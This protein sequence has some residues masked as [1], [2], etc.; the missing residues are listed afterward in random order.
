MS[1]LIDKIRALKAKTTE[2]GCTEDEALAAMAMARRLMKKHG[3]S[4]LDVELGASEADDLVME[5]L[6]D[7]AVRACLRPISQLTRTQIFKWRRVAPKIDLFSDVGKETVNRLRIVGLPHDIEIAEYFVMVCARAIDNT[8]REVASR[9][10]LN[11]TEKGRKVSNAEF[12]HY[13]ANF[14]RGMAHSL[15]EKIQ[16]MHE[17]LPGDD[18]RHALIQ[19]WFRENGITLRRVK[20][21]RR[22]GAGYGD[23]REAGDQFNLSRGVNRG[24]AQK[25]ISA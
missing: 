2:N 17:P 13:R 8:S 16:A 22:E 21:A 10:S 23:G 4:D 7:H 11:Q 18:Q 12:Q 5:G 25:F 6:V 3:V 15:A 9:W 19:T 24:E 1:K 20:G 14:A